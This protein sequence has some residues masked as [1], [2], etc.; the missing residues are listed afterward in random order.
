MHLL[1]PFDPVEQGLLDRP[2]QF[3]SRYGLH[4]LKIAMIFAGHV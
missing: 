1:Q 3:F 2:P 4:R